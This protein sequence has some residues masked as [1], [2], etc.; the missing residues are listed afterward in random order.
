MPR[1]EDFPCCGHENGCCPDFDE[2]GRQTNMRCT[3]G[4]VVP[5]T[6]RYS[7][8]LSCLR[9]V[10]IVDRHHIEEDAEPF[11]SERN[12]NDDFADDEDFEDFND[13]D[14]DGAGY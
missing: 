9:D 5:L 4:A 7:L 1:C 6:S 10:L 14:Y 11:Y 2:S 3:C 8:C 12:E 13:Q